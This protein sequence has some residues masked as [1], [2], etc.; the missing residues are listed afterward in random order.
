[1][2]MR[3]LLIAH[4]VLAY[5]GDADGPTIEDETG[6][7]AHPFVFDYER[8]LDPSLPDNVEPADELAEFAGRVCYQSFDRPN[9]KTATNDGY[10]ANIISQG[11]FSVLEH[12]SFTVYATGISRSLTHELIRH[13]HL[14]Y[15]ELS[16]RYVDVSDLEFVT[17]PR[18]LDV[19]DNGESAWL[20]R[21]KLNYQDVVEDIIERGHTRKDARGAARNYLPQGWETRIVCTGNF[22]AWREMLWK[23]LSPA[24][25]P[26]IRLFAREILKIAHD[27]APNTMADLWEEFS[28]DLA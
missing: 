23:R 24:A 17:P 20:D 13:R 7:L 11:H 5:A 16:Q 1:M 27:L 19:L 18:A 9:P 10:L 6:Y 22:R 28:G 2:S 4:T 25:E 12:A 3:V 26:E 15:S 14:S 8:N 21:Q